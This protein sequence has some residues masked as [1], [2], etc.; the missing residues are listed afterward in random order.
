VIPGSKTTLLAAGG[1]LAIAVLATVAVG[2][3]PFGIL[4]MLLAA[5]ALVELASV[6]GRDG[7]RPVLP[8]AAIP[9]LGLP[10]AAIVGSDETWE[11]LPAFL[12]AMLAA[13]FVLLL[14]GGRR[15]RVTETLAGTCLAGT[16]I[17]LGAGSLVLL[18]A[19]PGG[20][21]LALATLLLTAVPAAAGWAA[22]ELAAQPPRTVHAAELV[23]IAVV[24]GGLVAVFGAPLSPVVIAGV[25]AIGWGAA[26]AARALQPAS[27]EPALLL[28]LVGGCLLA[29]PATHVLARLSA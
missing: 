1:G 19:L 15:S 4:V 18:R 7:A 29:A 21:A 24:A 27:D 11:R 13:G 23:A 22:R 2:K 9:A 26:A 28:R 17:G 20:F 8:A 25:A 12:A 16:V 10:L 5:A 6:L 14:V 3:G